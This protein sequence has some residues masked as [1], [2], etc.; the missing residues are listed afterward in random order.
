MNDNKNNFYEQ[1][2]LAMK[3]ADIFNE[4]VKYS[5]T[6]DCSSSTRQFKSIFPST[7]K[8]YEKKTL[9]E[10]YPTVSNRV[11]SIECSEMNY[12]EN[13]NSKL[14]KRFVDDCR[15]NDSDNKY[16]DCKYEDNEYE[17]VLVRNNNK[18]IYNH[19]G[20]QELIRK[21]Y[22][23]KD[24]I[25]TISKSDEKIKSNIAI[26]YAMSNEIKINSLEDNLT[27]NRNEIDAKSG[28]NSSTSNSDDSKNENNLASKKIIYSESTSS[29][30]K[31]K[32]IKNI[33]RR[34][35]FSRFEFV[36]TPKMINSE[37][38]VEIEIPKYILD[39]LYKKMSS[40]TFFKKFTNV[41]DITKD[42][43]YFEKEFTK[44]SN[45][46]WTQLIKSFDIKNCEKIFFFDN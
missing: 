44:N 17:Y 41:R 6:R 35:E 23:N 9:I 22:Y 33:Y 21:E 14:K 30:E 46:S 38:E 28:D 20:R 39:I 7:E 5:L 15:G 8:I 29:L 11:K 45:D 4:K 25:S 16:T 24:K 3:L 2:V 13:E 40:H 42:F 10:N 19:D 31:I 26:N 37:M 36:N 43:Q 27:K 32:E 12:L 1:Q 34:R 18:K